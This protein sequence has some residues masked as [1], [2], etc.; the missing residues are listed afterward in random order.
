MT[1]EQIFKTIFTIGLVEIV[2][3]ATKNNTMLMAGIANFATTL[4]TIVSFIYI[5]GYYR[6]RRGEIGTEIVQSV[7][8]VPTRIRKTLKKILRESIPI[9][10]S[11]LMSSFNKNIDLFTIV[12]TLKRFMSESK[13]RYFVYIT[14][15]FKCA[16]CNWNGS[17][18]F[19]GNSNWR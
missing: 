16:I 10:L 9:S 13:N 19:K 8:Y 1:I 11:S 4:A 14:T 2:A 17:D 15:S 7:N 18:Y 6:I 12:K 5:Y 3:H